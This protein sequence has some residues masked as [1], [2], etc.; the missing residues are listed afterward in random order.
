M[1]LR[2]KTALTSTQYVNG[3]AWRDATLACCPLHPQGDCDF[4]RHGTYER[5]HPPGTLI[6]RWYCRAGHETFSL[7]PDCLA[8]RFSGTLAEFESTADQV[9]RA[10]TVTAV[11]AQIRMEI[12]L[13]GVL[14]WLRQRVQAVHTILVL[15]KGLLP[16]RFGDCVPTLADF[17]HVLRV[18]CVLVA[19]RE[20]AA[21]HLASLPPPLGF[22]RPSAAGAKP[23]KGIQHRAGPDPPH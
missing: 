14:R 8:A 2:Y 21:D 16:E 15:V 13:P 17:R 10:V 7:L 23:G 22:H 11:A 4:A 1:Q 6:A 9:E 12:G 5:V 20:I 18:D 3:Q 19:L